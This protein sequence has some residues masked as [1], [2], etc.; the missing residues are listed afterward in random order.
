MKDGAGRP[1]LGKIGDVLGKTTDS[2]SAAQAMCCSRP[3][4]R[5]DLLV[6]W[7][8]H[9]SLAGSVGNYFIFPLSLQKVVYG[10]GDPEEWLPS[11]R[12]HIAKRK[13]H[14]SRLHEWP[15]TST[16]MCCCRTLGSPTHRHKRRPVQ[17]GMRFS[18]LADSVYWWILPND[19]TCGNRA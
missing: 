12:M 4:T 2:A 5:Q 11:L 10:S 14:Q 16:L 3:R 9:C 6:T 1:H 18:S 7:E 15:R 17:S 19:V 8:N 13:Q